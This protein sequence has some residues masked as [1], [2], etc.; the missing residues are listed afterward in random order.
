MA[1]AAIK[2]NG[3]GTIGFASG[4]SHS[5][6]TVTAGDN[7]KSLNRAPDSIAGI[8]AKALPSVVTVKAD[9]AQESGTGTGFVFDTQGHILTNNHVVA[10]AAN[11]GGTI[12]VSSPTAATYAGHDG[13]QADTATTSRSS[14]ARRKRP[15]ARPRRSATRDRSRSA[16]PSS[17]S[18]RRSAWTAPSPPASSARSNRPV[19]VRRRG[20]QQ[21]ADVINA[22]Q[23][24]AAI[25]PGNSGG[26]LL[27]STAQVDR[28]QLRHPRRLDSTATPRSQ[29]AASASA[30][31]SRSTR[32]S[33]SPRC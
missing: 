3:N 7:T 26:P 2:G 8:A 14:G 19:D 25:N 30:S 18:A 17:P 22:I 5:S 21:Q 32:P 15:A 4:T 11:G 6:T 27:N 10:A 16:T 31:R 13:R 28:H 24:D 1:G 29:A 9:G 12:T 33:G 23:T 20:Q